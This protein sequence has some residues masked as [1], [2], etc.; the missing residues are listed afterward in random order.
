MGLLLALLE[1]QEMVVPSAGV[2][3]RKGARTIVSTNPH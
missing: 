1:V 2:C 3:K